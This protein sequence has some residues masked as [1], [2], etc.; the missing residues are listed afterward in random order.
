M[1][2]FFVPTENIG[3]NEIVIDSEDV[4]HISRVLRLNKGD[5]LTVCDGRGNDYTA[6]IDK[7]EKDK[8][9]CAI[10]ERHDSMSEPP[11]KVTLYQGIPKGTKMDYIIQKTT[12]L[13]VSDIV[14]VEMRRCVAK[15]GDGKSEA[16]KL[17]RWNKISAEAAKQSQRGI[18]PRVHGVMKFDEAIGA[19]KQ[20]DLCFAPYECEEKTSL[21]EILTGNGD[22]KTLAFMIGPEGGYDLMEAEKLRTAGIETVTLGR[23]ILRTETAGEAALA[24]IMYEIGDVNNI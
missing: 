16:K 19:M 10:L 24:M 11:V 6:R 21:K 23:R 8:I 1:P 5:E 9:I 18:I 15:I 2:R 4:A 13:G 20:A 22:I 12:E 17:E 14:P 7:T 3:E